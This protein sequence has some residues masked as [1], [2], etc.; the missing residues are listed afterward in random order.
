MLGTGL[1]FPY[2]ASLKLYNHHVNGSWCNFRSESNL[3]MPLPKPA[4]TELALPARL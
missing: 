1:V 3:V 2:V 4:W